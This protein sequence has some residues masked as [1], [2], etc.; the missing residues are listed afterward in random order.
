MTSASFSRRLA[1]LVMLASSLGLAACKVG[2][3]GGSG[4]GQTTVR[5]LNL[6]SDI[7]SADL[8]IGGN[9]QFSSLATG[10]L[11]NYVTL[12]ANSYAINVASA[13]NSTALFTSSYSLAKDQHYTAVVWGPQSSLH[14]ST[15]PEDED[16]ANIASGNT[17]VRMFNATTETGAL[18][19]YLTASGADLSATTPTQTV[20]GGQL[21]GYHEIP[22]GT[23]ELRVTGVGNSADIRLDIPAITL[24]ASQFA[25]LVFTAGSG[26]VLVNGT[27][28]VQQG[29]ATVLANTKARVRVIASVDLGGLVNANIGGAVLASGLRSPAIGNYS[30]VDAGNTVPTV[31]TVGSTD[32]INGTLAF[33]AGADYTILAYGTTAA[34]LHSLPITDD[35]RLPLSPSRTKIRLI[36]AVGG[37]DPLTLLVDNSVISASSNVLAGTASAYAQTASSTGAQ[38]EVDSPSAQLYVTTL[39][40]GDKLLSQG[41]YTMFILSGRTIGPPTQGR[42]INE[43][44]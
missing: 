4:G 8:Y 38:I 6:T 24:G 1:L 34:P 2:G 23:Y 21:S 5:A 19:V 10:V 15:L 35:N 29:A 36:N 17:R 27:Q 32:V 28:I 42:L 31:V 43:R 26:G 12:D 22:A 3:G 39:T 33:S 40:N 9:K 37:S 44:P 30:L 14:V 18:D 7:Q 25:S 13:G 11:A 16:S 41:V 20:S